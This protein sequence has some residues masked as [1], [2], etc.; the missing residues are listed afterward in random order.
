MNV[1]ATYGFLDPRRT[2]AEHEKV[3]A[4]FG[5]ELLPVPFVR[6]AGFYTLL[7]DIPQATTHLD[8]CSLGGQLHF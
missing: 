1:K 7:A 3:R 4:R 2:V 6:L 8:R 5:L